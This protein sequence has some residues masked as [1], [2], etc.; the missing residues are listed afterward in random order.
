[1]NY[2]GRR[3]PVKAADR[4]ARQGP[5]AYYGASGPIDTIDE[6]LFDGEF[7]LVAEDGAKGAG[8]NKVVNFSY[9][10]A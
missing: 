10:A 2:D 4:A 8:K 1:V 9:G 5:Y 6:Y 3:I 7:L